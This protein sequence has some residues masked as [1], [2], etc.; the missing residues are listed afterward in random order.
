MEILYG[1]VILLVFI[2]GFGIGVSIPFFVKKYANEIIEK[3]KPQIIE[4]KEENTEPITA[5]NLTKEIQEEW[6]Y[7]KS[8]K[9]GDDINE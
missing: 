6:F 2:M 9:S 3:N 1:I 4:K 7:G 8:E 5:K